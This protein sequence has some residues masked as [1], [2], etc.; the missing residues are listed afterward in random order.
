VAITLLFVHEPGVYTPQPDLV[1]LIV[2]VGASFSIFIIMVP[3]LLEF[4][5]LS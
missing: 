3:I 5:A 1:K 2:V 4:P